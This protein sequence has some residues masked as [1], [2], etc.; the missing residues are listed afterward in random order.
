[1]V[2]LLLF[3]KDGFGIKYPMKVGIPLKKKP[4]QTSQSS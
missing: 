1:M 3:Y 4:N 2:P